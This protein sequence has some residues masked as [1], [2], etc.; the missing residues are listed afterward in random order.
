MKAER[1]LEHAEELAVAPVAGQMYQ[2]RFLGHW[3]SGQVAVESSE[4][5]PSCP[6]NEVP[7]FFFA[8]VRLA[9]CFGLPP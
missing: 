6:A 8:A 1:T 5:D 3:V 4:Q 9:I 7:S 2:R